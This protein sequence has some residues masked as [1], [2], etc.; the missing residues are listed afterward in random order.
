MFH[1]LMRTSIELFSLHKK[2]SKCS[3]SKGR[4]H[5]IIRILKL[6]F[7]QHRAHVLLKK[8]AYYRLK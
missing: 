4:P 3:C 7:L 5:C 2:A 8:L 1:L 6:T